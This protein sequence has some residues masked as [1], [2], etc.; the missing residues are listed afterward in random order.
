MAGDCCRLDEATSRRL[1]SEAIASD[2]FRAG[3]RRASCK[4][5]A[6]LDRSSR[7][8]RL[9]RHPTKPKLIGN[10]V[11]IWRSDFERVNGYDENF[12]GWGC[13]DDDLRY[14]L[15]QAGVAVESILRWTL[16]LSPVAPRR[17]HGAGL[18]EGW[19]QRP[20]LAPQG[21]GRSL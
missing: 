3:R 17:P 9:I 6:K 11:G 21:A 16:R 19:G 13:E 4:R 18:V 12:E 5:L 10:N 20:I 1:T 15:R 8:Y 14:R 7:F 2:A